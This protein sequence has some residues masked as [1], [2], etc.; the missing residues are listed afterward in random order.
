MQKQMTGNVSELRNTVEKVLLCA[1]G[2][3]SVNYFYLKWRYYLFSGHFLLFIAQLGSVGKFSMTTMVA[4]LKKFKM[5]SK[6]QG[7]GPK[8]ELFDTRSINLG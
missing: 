1:S 5:I 3:I 7:Y 2:W 8:Y 6:G 4:I